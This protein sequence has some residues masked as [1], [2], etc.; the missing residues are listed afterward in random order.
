ME[1]I[2][3]GINQNW[4]W[5]GPLIILCFAATLDGRAIPWAI[6]AFNDAVRPLTKGEA[7]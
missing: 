6:G 1:A 2:I 7:I 3:I 4:M 5:L